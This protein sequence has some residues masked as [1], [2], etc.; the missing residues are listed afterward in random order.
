MRWKDGLLGWFPL[1]P[2]ETG[3]VEPQ[4]APGRRMKLSGHNYGDWV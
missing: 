4:T 1:W 2:G 3:R